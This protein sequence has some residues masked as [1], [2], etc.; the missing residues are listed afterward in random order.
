MLINHLVSLELSFTK[1]CQRERDRE[2]ELETDRQDPF[3]VRFTTL[4]PV[5]RMAWVWAV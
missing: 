2:T 5:V 1:F 3:E 4:V